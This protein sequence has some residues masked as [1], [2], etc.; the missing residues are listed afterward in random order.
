MS[1][2]KNYGRILFPIIALIVLSRSTSLSQP[3]RT[4]NSIFLEVGGSG[5]GYVSF[6]Y[7]RLISNS[8]SVRMG[9][10]HTNFNFLTDIT[11]NSFPLLVNYLA[12]EN[13]SRFEAGIGVDV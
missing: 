11:V 12:G 9:Y 10:S 5:Y 2:L 3:E 13:N 6:N 8:F 4:P 7:D 1:Q